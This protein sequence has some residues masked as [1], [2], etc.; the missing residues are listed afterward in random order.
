[1]NPLVERFRVFW[2][3][4]QVREKAFLMALAAIVGVALLAQL[5]WSSHQSRVRLKQQVP[6]LRQQVQTLERK[7]ADLQ[8]LASQPQRPMPPDGNALLATAIAAAGPAGL[9]DIR[10]QLK[11]E[12]T[13]RVRLRATLPFDRWLA[14]TAALQRDGQIR[15][16]SCRVEAAAAPGSATIDALF[17]LPEPG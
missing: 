8:Q 3:G 11:L 2:A 9:P 12:S 15:L 14:W 16:V 10:S 7:A 4:R 1:M 6:Q 13:R 17:A 5:L